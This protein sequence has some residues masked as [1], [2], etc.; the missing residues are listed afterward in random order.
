MRMIPTSMANGVLPWIMCIVC[1]ASLFVSSGTVISET[2]AR[3]E[4][5]RNPK[6]MINIRD[7]IV[8]T[9]IDPRSVCIFIDLMMHFTLLHESKEQMGSGPINFFRTRYMIEGMHLTSTQTGGATALGTEEFEGTIYDYMIIPLQYLSRQNTDKRSFFLAMGIDFSYLS[10]RTIN[11]SC[12]RI[13]IGFS[14]E[15]EDLKKMVMW[16]TR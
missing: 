5:S 11:L 1:I 4:L 13:Y 16:I 2:A 15:G 6:V 12:D 9:T 8:V 7:G 14:Y 10:R 3:E